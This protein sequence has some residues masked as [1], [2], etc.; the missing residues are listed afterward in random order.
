MNISFWPELIEELIES[1]KSITPL[2]VRKSAR[3]INKI[4]QPLQIFPLSVY[5]IE[6]I[7]Y[8][9]AK[10]TNKITRIIAGQA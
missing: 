6:N 1:S 10:I 7:P 8:L 4:N 2:H 3:M 5:V 9:D